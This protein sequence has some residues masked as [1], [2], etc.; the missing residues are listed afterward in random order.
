MS[1]LS[2]L[3]ALLAV[4]ATAAPFGVAAAGPPCI[5]ADNPLNA[6]LQYFPPSMRI[7]TA[8]S[9]P[10]AATVTVAGDFA[11][12]YHPSF[13]VVQTI[14]GPHHPSA[15]TG[16]TYILS[17]CGAAKPTTYPNGTNI[18][19][20]AVHFAV[21]LTGVAI[22]T[23][24]PVTFIEMLG[25]L[26]S[27]KVLD[28]TTVHSPCLQKLEEEAL[29]TGQ[30]SGSWPHD[31]ATNWT[32]L[33]KDHPTVTGVFTDSWSTGA[34]KTPK[35]IVFD[36]SSDPGAMAR[37]EWI[38]FMSVFFNAE[39]KANL[40]FERELAAYKA[41]AAATA[42]VSAANAAK[43]TC[44]WVSLSWDNKYIVGFTKYKTDLCSD[45]GMTPVTNATL[46]AANTYS[47]AYASA[48]EFH[49]LLK[50]VDVIIDESYHAAVKDANLTLVM[51]KLGFNA[52][53]TAAAVLKPGA[54]LL[55]TDLMISDTVTKFYANGSGNVGEAS[56]AMDWY[57]SAIARPALVLIDLAATVWP[58]DVTAPA[59]GCSQYFRDVL[60]GE[61]PI[62]NGKE[63]CAA[64]T[65]A[66]NEAKCINNPIKTSDVTPPPP[67]ASGAMSARATA[68]SSV[69]LVLASLVAAAVM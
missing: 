67:P 2:A 12:T 34:S 39:D 22:G 20:S 13:K 29:I 64:W 30:A 32:K 68:G 51:A 10:G 27:V 26:D 9:T 47:Q 11:V 3:V 43:K 38:K 6:S 5:T 56:N 23:S 54:L 44:A 15:C 65:S 53:D 17:I 52:N 25:L 36:A 66:A 69:L 46:L 28:P 49:A 19:A 8:G 33:L 58:A 63:A 60:K 55:R 59:A 31:H 4:V 35:D 21:P 24:A 7:T 62:I 16:K 1:R 57:E 14:C 42:T 41:T 37:A 18:S 48:A 61:M 50:T 40:Y 45:A